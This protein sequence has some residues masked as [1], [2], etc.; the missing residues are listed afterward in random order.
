MIVLDLSFYM[1]MFLH[2]K[3]SKSGINRVGIIEKQVGVSVTLRSAIENLVKVCEK[4][5]NFIH[6]NTVKN[7][8]EIS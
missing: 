4:A 7:A 3:W 6:E 8:E 2:R 1:L 5:V